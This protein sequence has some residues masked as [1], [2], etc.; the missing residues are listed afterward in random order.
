[1]PLPLGLLLG[2]GLAGEGLSRFQQ[3]QSRQQELERFQAALGTPGG[4]VNAGPIAGNINQ[5]G[6][7][8]IGTLPEQFQDPVFGALQTIF[9]GGGNAGINGVVGDT[10]QNLIFPQEQNPLE[11]LNVGVA[12]NPNLRQQV[13]VN[14]LTGEQVATIGAPFAQRAL[15]EQTIGGNRDLPATQ[16]ESLG[17]AQGSLA[18]SEQLLKSYDPEFSGLGMGGVGAGIE[19]EIDRRTGRN[20]ERVTFWNNVEEDKVKFVRA[21][22]G[23]NA[24]D[25]DRETVNQIYPNPAYSDETNQALLENL[26]QNK[27]RLLQSLNQGLANAG[28]NTGLQSGV[29]VDID[30]TQP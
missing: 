15:I 25:R 21:T 23:G 6:T 4:Q 30:L 2:I 13:G 19:L 7:G 1:M 12:G 3:S 10:L 16:A 18:G 14:P 22:F 29:Q 28:F 27:Q 20:T 26:R 5:P 11:F 9:A 17:K 24:S 8:F